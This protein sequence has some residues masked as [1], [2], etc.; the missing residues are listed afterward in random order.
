MHVEDVFIKVKSAH[1][2]IEYLRDTISNAKSIKH[3][4]KHT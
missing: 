1:L 3:E 2:I 4:F